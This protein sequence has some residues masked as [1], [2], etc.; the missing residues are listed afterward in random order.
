MML[1]EWDECT[2][3]NSYSLPFFIIMISDIDDNHVNGIVQLFADDI[4]ISAKI[5]NEGDIELLQ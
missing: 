1:E 4:K 2:T 5:K 3:G